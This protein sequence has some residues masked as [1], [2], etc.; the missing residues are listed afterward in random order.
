MAFVED[1]EQ[2]EGS[3]LVQT[4]LLWSFAATGTSELGQFRN[5]DMMCLLSVRHC[6]RMPHFESACFR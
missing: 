2:F 1:I 3:F 4:Q 6:S 5:V